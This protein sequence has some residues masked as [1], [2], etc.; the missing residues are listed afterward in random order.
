[1]IDFL[2]YKKTDVTRSNKPISIAFSQGRKFDILFCLLKFF[3]C[4][5]DFLVYEILLA[6]E[7][8][9]NISFIQLIK[10]YCLGIS[11]SLKLLLLV[12][13]E[14]QLVVAQEPCVIVQYGDL[15]VLLRNQC[16]PITL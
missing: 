6:S 7:I 2:W 1:M 5:P 16:L 11:H 15:A 12:L 4:Q 9:R 14:S 3:L 8:F 10:S 13:F